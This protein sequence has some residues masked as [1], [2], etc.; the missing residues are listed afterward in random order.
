MLLLLV[1][2]AVVCVLAVIVHRIRIIGL[3]GGIGCGKSSAA[4][5]IR[6]LGPTVIDVDALAHKVTEPGTLAHLLIKLVFGPSV[7]QV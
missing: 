4:D 2:V 1:A 6:A 7:Q 3:T 5:A